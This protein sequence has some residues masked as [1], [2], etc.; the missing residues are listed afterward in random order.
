VITVDSPSFRPDPALVSV[1]YKWLLGPFGVGCLCVAAQHRDGDPLEENWINRIAGIVARK[2][3]CWRGRAHGIDGT[4]R[5]SGG[6]PSELV[7]WRRARD[8]A[9][10]GLRTRVGPAA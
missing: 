4:D 6:S 3:E 9:R 8:R 10:S 5:P 2:S 1:G 7:P